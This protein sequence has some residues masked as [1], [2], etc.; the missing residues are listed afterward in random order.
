MSEE[1]VQ[2]QPEVVAAE[3][4]VQETLDSGIAHVHKRVYNW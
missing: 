3:R 1:L 2:Y 4:R